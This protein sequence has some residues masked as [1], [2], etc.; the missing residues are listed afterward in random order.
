MKT[1]TKSA[2][3]IAQLERENTVLAIALADLANVGA[4]WFGC[5][6]EF[7]VGITRPTGGCGGI[8]IVRRNGTVSAFYFEEFYRSEMEHIACCITGE[9]T[10]SNR[11]LLRR[12]A[13]LEDAKAYVGE[14]QRAA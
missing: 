1:M 4:K 3:R 10:G 2:Q 6:R 14:Q 7:C 5:S 13:V 9:N 8:A 11:E 12:R